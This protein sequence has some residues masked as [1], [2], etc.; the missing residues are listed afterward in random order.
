MKMQVVLDWIR[1]NVFTV[2]FIVVMVAALIAFPLVAAW[3]G[4]AIEQDVRTRKSKLRE[5]EQL[6]KTSVTIEQP[7]RSDISETVLVNRRLLDE[8]RE[9]T[10][11]RREDAQRVLAASQE[12][13]RKERGVLMARLFPDPPPAEAEVLPKQF[14]SRLHEAHEEL[15]DDVD[16][17]SPPAPE[18]LATELERQ[19]SQFLTQTLQ[20]TDAASLTE[21]EERRLREK[22]SKVRMSKYVEAAD[23]VGVY[24]D[25]S[26]LNL[27][28]WDQTRSYPMSELFDW[29]WQYWIN[30][31]VLRAIA[32]ANAGSGG[33]VV[34]APVKRVLDVY[35]QPMAAPRESRSGGGGSG[36]GAG[37]GA[38]AGAGFGMGGTGGG[39]GRRGNT[40]PPPASPPD[41]KKEV[42][43]DYDVSFTG[44][45]SNPLYDVR[46]VDVRMIVDTAR[47]PE[48]LDA[49]AKQNFMTVLDVKMQ[50]ADAYDALQNGFVYAPG[51]VSQVDLRLET[52]WLRSWTSQFMPREVKMTLGVP[53]EQSVSLR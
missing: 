18:E 6:E 30:Q 50:P 16:A 12:H 15:L 38:G 39:G 31:D 43:L 32:D 28:A 49:I 21:D 33:A 26:A 37:I 42:R 20:K 8:F 19:R 48:V 3:L 44:R 51:P 35:I 13:N 4:D 10:E 7:G 14:H 45:M 27:P 46:I 23:S 22:L 40:A 5:L 2:V 11:A 47:I 25:K 24:I 34:R 1:T 9:L 52:I 17:G 41:P 29:Q 36:A 53:V